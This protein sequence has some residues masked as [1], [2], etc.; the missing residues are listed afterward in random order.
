M[1]QQEKISALPPADPALDQGQLA[2]IGLASVRR[3]SRQLWTDHNTHDPGITTLE[4]LAYALTDLAYRARFPI[5]DLLAVADDN[6]AEM[7]KLFA[8]AGRILPCRPVTEADYRKLLI[9]L[10]G[11]KN[12][13]LH[14]LSSWLY[15]DP[16]SGRL[17]AKATG[18]KT[19]RP[20]EV[21][22]RYRVLLDYMP[23]R[24]STVARQAVDREV[25]ATLHANRS[26]CTDFVGIDRVGEQPFSLCAEID[27]LP[28][29]DVDQV[30][31][32]IAFAVDR[33]MAPPVANYSLAEMQARRRA[34]GSRWSIPEIFEGP[35]LVNGFI[36][37]EELA[38][39]G[40][41]SE[42]R[43][44]DVI[45]VIMDIPGVLAIRD[46]LL[47]AVD[48]LGN[49]VAPAD[50]WRL[51]VPPGCQP[52]LAAT[53]GRL[54]F[55]KK[56]LPVPPAASQVASRLAALCEA[57][58]RK[59]EDGVQEDLPLPLGR[60]RAPGR[61]LSFQSHFPALYGISE[62]GLAA[63]ATPQRR[64][65]AL[66]F[67]A[68]LLFFDQVMANYQ[69]QL[70]HVRDLFSTRPDQVATYFSQLVDSFPDWE[71]I[72]ATDF[73]AALL[74][75]E[76]VEPERAGLLRRNRFLDHLLARYGEDFQEY[77]AL[78]QARFGMGAGQAASAKCVFLDEYPELGGRRGLAYNA[79]LAGADDLWNSANVSGF[80]RRVARLLDIGNWQRRN[81][82]EVAY[83]TYAEV[84]ATPNDEYRFRVRHPVSG[85]ILLSSSS[86]YTSPAKARDEMEMAIARA[87]RPEGYERKT[88]SDGRHYFNIIDGGGA[89]LARRIEYFA[90]VD[91]M[92]LAIAA[93]IAHLRNYYSGEGMYVIEHLLLLAEP[94]AAPFMD[95]C[96]DPACLDCAELDPYSNRIS[97]VLPAYSGR[98]RDMDFRRFVEETLRQE[99]PAHILPRI[100]WVNTDDMAAIEQAY[101]AWL[102]SRAA[103]SA[104]LAARQ[105]ALIEVLTRA[106]NVYPSSALHPCGQL[107]PPPFV[108]GR[109]AL[110]S[111]DETPAV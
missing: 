89:V 26:L 40:L 83:D 74:G 77:T 13:W 37:D 88:A 55:Y 41:R 21:H 56:N 45:S 101:R 64:A 24:N 75:S 62:F 42:V 31:A 18:S 100:C 106:K 51:P 59:L 49:A 78:M 20:I 80:E 38:A 94:V 104:D 97:I 84:D 6:P 71:K 15:A 11:V 102:S 32:E 90:T 99:T 109:T 61:Y 9:D 44:S 4:M 69:A 22:G 33:F 52:R 76:V 50:R 108:L 79:A 14:P 85:K 39:A 17:T 30:A 67:K 68:W 16:A 81:L 47:N 48:A 25:M 43:L 98:F 35:A 2:A 19:E 105:K 27:L 10:P 34:D 103:G 7:A 5:E 53:P 12:A 29:A 36:D 92:E 28:A 96:V 65:Q 8:S 95:I 57:E 72:Y 73:G 54:L 93:L 107:E 63:N 58:R 110:G 82:S 60:F 111:A 1:L 46:I 66:Q 91:A 86:N 70:A 3:L 23:D 87:Q